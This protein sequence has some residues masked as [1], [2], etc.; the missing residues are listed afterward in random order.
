MLLRCHVRSEE[1]KAVCIG[2]G[3]RQHHLLMRSHLSREKVRQRLDVRR[4][5]M[6]VRGGV[7]GAE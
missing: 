2:H 4:G 3:I 5:D 6:F 1:E 7:H